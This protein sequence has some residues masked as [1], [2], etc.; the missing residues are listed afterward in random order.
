MFEKLHFPQIDIEINEEEDKYFFFDIIR[1]KKLIMTPE[2]WVRQHVVHYFL[3]ISYPRGLIS[4]ES[5]L[6]YNRL[7]KRTDIVVR[8]REGE[9]FMLVEC[10]A[11][12]VKINKK[13]IE[14]ASIYNQELNA[15]YLAV[16]NGLVWYCFLMDYNNQEYVQMKEFPVFQ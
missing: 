1:K 5:G 16:T 7:L 13:V 4:L 11:S 6:K 12:Y 14:Q 15:K 3:S 10:K 2:E 8:D 9:V